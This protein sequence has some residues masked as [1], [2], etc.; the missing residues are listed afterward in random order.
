MFSNSWEKVYIKFLILDIKF[1]LTWSE[2]DMCENILKLQTNR[3][4]IV[5]QSD[6]AII[7]YDTLWYYKYLPGQRKHKSFWIHNTYETTK[8]LKVDL[9]VYICTL[10]LITGID[11]KLWAFQNKSLH[12]TLYLNRKLFW[13]CKHN[14]S[15]G[16]F[17]NLQVDMVIHRFFH[18]SKTKR[19][20][21]TVIKIF[22]RN[23]RIPLLLQQS[24][25][26]G[27]LE[28]DNK[29]FLIFNMIKY[30]SIFEIIFLLLLKCIMKIPGRN[31]KSKWYKET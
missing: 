15:L 27:F 21:F 14:I 23:L 13:F 22:K 7:R 5:C 25:I 29:V 10:P 31:L 24:V 26:F 3:T 2:K 20:W 12:K 30:F 4:I 6:M 19:L 9:N 17:C 11:C 16:S 8:L 1:R 18:C 28:A